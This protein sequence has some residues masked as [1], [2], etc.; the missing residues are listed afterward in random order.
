MSQILENTTRHALLEAA[1]VEFAQHGLKGASVRAICARAGASANAVTYHFGSKEHLYRTILDRFAVLQLEQVQL[2][3]SETPTSPQEFTTR[4]EL[5]LRGLLDAYMDNRQ[6]LRIVLREFQ[7]LKPDGDM[8][9]VNELTKISYAVTDFIE[10][11]K[12]KGLVRDDVDAALVTGTL[13]DR[14]LN[15]VQF[16]DAHVRLFETTSTDP[17][18]RSQ[19][20]RDSLGIVLRGI[21]P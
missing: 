12:A 11:A 6:T 10:R 8:S 19:W 1:T 7:T 20:V 9:A 14:I 18:Y 3:L 16:A 4:L 17:A 2:T 21:S 5:F 13:L 15:Q